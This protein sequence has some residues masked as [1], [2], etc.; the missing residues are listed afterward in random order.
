[1]GACCIGHLAEFIPAR[2][3]PFFVTFPESSAGCWFKESEFTALLVPG[4]PAHLTRT[5]DTLAARHW[6]VWR[7]PR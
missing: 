7:A 5:P 3:F 6:P 4:I 2:D 1:M